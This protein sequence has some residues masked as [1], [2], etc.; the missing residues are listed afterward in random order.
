MALILVVEDDRLQRFAAVQALSKAGHQVLEAT[1]GQTGLAMAQS[2][3]PDLLVCDVMMPGLDG[4]QVLAALRSDPTIAG[5]PV[6]LL[7]SLAERTQVR[8]GMNAGA[9]DY[10]T[11]PFSFAELREA[12]AALLAKSEVH[13][14]HAQQTLV[15]KLVAAMDA[16][17]HNLSTRYEHQLAAELNLRWNAAEASAGERHYPMATVA[18]IDVLG[19][20]VA[21]LASRLGFSAVRQALQHARDVQYVFGAKHLTLQGE[22]L[23]AVFADDESRPVHDAA[24]RAARAAL[25]LAGTRPVAVA[26]GSSAPAEL[27][28][29]AAVVL[30]SGPITALQLGDPLHAGADD[31]LLSGP[32]LAEADMLLDLCRT[33]GWR[34]ACSQAMLQELGAAATLGDRTTLASH[35]LEGGPDGGLTASEFLGLA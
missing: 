29:T 33:Q 6:I 15:P 9:D 3:H 24:L 27:T 26:A 17:K 20:G 30:H 2:H 21:E 14:T 13:Q 7:T 28:H 34:M 11:K 1:D 19:T 31:V 8:Q 35:E 32:A 12:V 23:M 10:L 5:T 16:Q 25:A 18:L 22:R 4:Y